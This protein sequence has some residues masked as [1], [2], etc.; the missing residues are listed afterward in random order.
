MTRP[1]RLDLSGIPQHVVQRGVDRRPS[2]VLE[3]HYKE[4]LRHLHEQA[5][6]FDCQVHA[7]AL[8]CNHA[9]LLVTPREAGGVGRLMQE[10]GRRYVAFFNFTMGRTGTLWEGRYKSCLVDSES[11]VLRCYRYIELNPVRAGITKDPGSFRW[12]SFGFNGLGHDNELIAPHPAYMSLGSSRLER[13]AAYR[14]LVAQGCEH[15]DADEIR[16]MT[17]RQ[18]AFGSKR[19]QAELEAVHGR[20]MGIINRGR[21]RKVET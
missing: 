10:L 21:P 5:N 8:M 19:F 14:F 16:T 1:T 9:H 12:S 15:R 17:A 13:A 2:F 11:Y 6:K 18:R 20:P 4:F 7:Y 3:I